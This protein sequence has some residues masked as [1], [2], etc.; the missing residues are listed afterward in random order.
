MS[1]LSRERTLGEV[2]D[3]ATRRLF[4]GRNELLE[5][6][7]ST[8]ATRP[9]A[10]SIVFVHGPGG[11][12]KTA[13]LSAIRDQAIAAHVQAIRLDMRTIEPTRAAFL[14]RFGAGLEWDPAEVTLEKL[15]DCGRVVVLVDTWE[16]AE[17]LDAWFCEQ[18]LCCLPSDALVVVAGRKPP[19]PRWRIESGWGGLL[20]VVQLHNLSSADTRH[21]LDLRG[22]DAAVHDRILALTHGH[23]LALSL[24]ADV[25]EHAAAGKEIV[26]DLET[27]PD[28]VHTLIERFIGEIPD[29]RR[30][31]ALEVCA[32]AR[33]TTED[34]LRAVLGGEDA[35]EL[36]TWLRSC[37]FVEEGRYGVF[38]HDLA[39]EVLD[40]DL[41]GRDPVA[42][43]DL[44]HR[45]RA[46]VSQRVCDAV[47]FAQQRAT[48]DLLFL[49]RLNPVMRPL[50]DWSTLDRVYADR[51]VDRDR[52]AVLAMTERHQGPQQA[53]MVR[54]WLDR[55]SDAFVVF[56]RTDRDVQG[57]A[58]LLRLHRALPEDI[59]ADPGARAMWEYAL[60]HAALRTGES[61]VATRFMVDGDRNQE[62]PSPTWTGLSIVHIINVLDEQRLALTFFGAVQSVDIAA[63]CEYVDHHRVPQAEFAIDGRAHVVFAHDWRR[64][65]I[66]AF[67]EL[68]GRRELDQGSGLAMA[69]GLIPPDAAPVLSRSAFA[70]A[71]RDALRDRHRP[72]H[73]MDNPLARSRLVR[74]PTTRDAA[75][76]D[77]VATLV[78]LL[79]EA[80]AVLAKDPREIKLHRAI[81][82]TF[83]RPAT[84]QERAAEAL[85]LPFS[86]YRRHLRQGLDRIVNRLWDLELGGHSSSKKWP[87]D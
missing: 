66:A 11:V 72:E 80:V 64:R 51:L 77:P 70:A 46:H 2:R 33:Y 50:F 14:K 71:V 32:H 54:H 43:V 20:R 74:E 36:L 42:Y 25:I 48:A 35:G 15:A 56:R 78:T 4:V 19:G 8:L 68:M 67:M 81:E 52:E 24:V 23:P 27:S 6:V 31:Q 57:F 16:V 34:L 87:G 28:I 85:G 3:G 73:L 63:Y 7:R 10:F 29:S 22:V 39:R 30:R 82:R 76:A 58:A 84:T 49:H 65:G 75:D 69:P 60:R 1:Q 5:L 26:P 83:L 40:V 12:G 38:P 17:P 45:I 55:Q 62:R 59:A 9:R 44:H 86:T 37:S 21:Y 47:G 61:V 13:L 79:D 18:F 41:R 53:A